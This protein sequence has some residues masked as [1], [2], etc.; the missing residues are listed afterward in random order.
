MVAKVERSADPV[1]AKLDTLIR[2]QA[3]SLVDG[4]QSQREKLAFLDKAGLSSGEIASIVGMS[5]A[6]VSKALYKIRQLGKGERGIV[7]DA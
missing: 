7:E 1:A 4:M 3:T 2:L 6:N 5:T